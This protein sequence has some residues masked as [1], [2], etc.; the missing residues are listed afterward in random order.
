MKIGVWSTI[1]L[2]SSSANKGW[3]VL[4][5]KFR[6]KYL[7]VISSRLSKKIGLY[8]KVQELFGKTFVTQADA[9]LLLLLIRIFYVLSPNHTYPFRKKS[10][11][12]KRVWNDMKVLT[13]HK[14][15]MTFKPG[16]STTNY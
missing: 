16:N 7:S 2:S 13:G 12:D 10:V 9:V 11:N 15:D 1:Q 3:S 6:V 8:L 4:I 14:I 5:M